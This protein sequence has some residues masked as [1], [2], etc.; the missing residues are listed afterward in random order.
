MEEGT[1][2]G[3]EAGSRAVGVGV[4]TRGDRDGE[5]DERCAEEERCCERFVIAMAAYIGRYISYNN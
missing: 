5:F 3:T 2:G 1:V 4:M